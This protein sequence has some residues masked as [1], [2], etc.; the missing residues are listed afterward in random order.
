MNLASTE[1]KLSVEAR[2][3]EEDASRLRAETLDAKGEIVEAEIIEAELVED[4]ED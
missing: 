1:S 4:D 3:A 2:K